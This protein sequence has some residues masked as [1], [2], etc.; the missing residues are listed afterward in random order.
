MPIVHYI[1]LLYIVPNNTKPCTRNQD[2]KCSQ[3]ITPSGV[4]AAVGAPWC[5]GGGVP[6]LCRAVGVGGT[7]GAGGIAVLGQCV[8]LCVL[9]VVC[10]LGRR[11]LRD[12][13]KKYLCLSSTWKPVSTENQ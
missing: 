5:A 3:P 12:G 10:V 13:K 11:P 9:G 1:L 7:R 2:K 6:H 8:L 4:W